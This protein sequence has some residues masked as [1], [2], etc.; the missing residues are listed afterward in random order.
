MRFEWDTEK[1]KINIIKHKMDFKTAAL[2]FNDENRVEYYD[3]EHSQEEDRY[4]AIGIIGKTLM[5]ATVVFTDRGESI[6]IISARKA[7]EKERR[8]YYDH[9]QGY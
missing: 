6:R 7:T 3:D 5:V 1:E 2:L 4:K 9:Y 8:L